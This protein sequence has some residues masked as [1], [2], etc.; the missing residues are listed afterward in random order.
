MVNTIPIDFAFEAEFLDAQ[1]KPTAASLV[2]PETYNKIKGSA[3]GK[4]EAKST[5]RIGLDLGANGNI[6]QLAEV[7]AL[8]LQLKAL[9]SADGS[10]ALNAEQ[11]ISLK[12]QLELDGKI[13]ADLDNL[14]D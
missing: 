12:L 2:I 1:G 10:C 4:T 7:D 3:D 13:K 9:R 11:Y 14:I 8:R 5:L 6:N